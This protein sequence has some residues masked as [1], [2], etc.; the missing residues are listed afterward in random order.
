MPFWRLFEHHFYEKFSDQ[1]DKIAGSEALKQ[2]I[3]LTS[4]DIFLQNPGIEN[5]DYLLWVSAH[6]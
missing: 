1:K 6:P 5:I 2:S 3:F 4:I